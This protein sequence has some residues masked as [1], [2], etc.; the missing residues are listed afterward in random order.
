MDLT[1]TVTSGGW[2]VIDYRVSPDLWI[3]GTFGRSYDDEARGG[4]LAQVGLSLNL[5]KQRYQFARAGP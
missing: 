3:N 2:L 4:L 5:S 1:H